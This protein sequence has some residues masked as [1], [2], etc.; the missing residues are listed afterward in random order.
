MTSTEAC[1]ASETQTIEE[2]LYRIASDLSLLAD[3][4]IEIQSIE[5]ER[6]ERRPVGSGGIHISFKMTIRHLGG[7]AEGCLLLPLAEGIT[8][9][10][11][12]MMA[13]DEEVEEQR[14]RQTLDRGAKDAMLELAKFIASAAGSALGELPSAEFEVESDGCQG[15]RAGVRPALKYNEGDTLIV[16]RVRAAIHDFP[17][18]EALLILPELPLR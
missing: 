14:A 6:W 17:E 11:Y 3:H 8:L 4:D 15:V 10:K 9:A 18:F 1:T 16:G 7:Q 5:A 13:E 2:V 12:L